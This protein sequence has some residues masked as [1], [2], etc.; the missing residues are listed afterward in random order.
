MSETDHT[1]SAH[2]SDG[3]ELRRRAHAI[4]DHL[5]PCELKAAVLALEELEVSVQVRNEW[6]DRHAADA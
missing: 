5:P 4:I 2:A 1:P 6:T 3:E